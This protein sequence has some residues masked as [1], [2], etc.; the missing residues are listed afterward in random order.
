M[1]AQADQAR[2]KR[3]SKSPPPDWQQDG[4]G[5]PPREQ[6]Q[7][8]RRTAQAARVDPT[9]PAGR[10]HEVGGDIHP[11][12][13]TLHDRTR[14]TDPPRPPKGGRA[15]I[16]RGSR[17]ARTPPD[18]HAQPGRAGLR[19]NSPGG[20]SDSATK[21]REWPPVEA[22]SGG[23]R[24]AALREHPRTPALRP[25]EPGLAGSSGVPR[26]WRSAQSARLKV[27]HPS[28]PLTSPRQLRHD[29]PEIGAV[30]ARLG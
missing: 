11:R 1:A 15:Y 2:V 7:I 20:G 28:R 6:D 9:E 21:E 29:A 12:G 4:H 5:K 3:W 19:W 25:A 10:S 24:S 17:A 13:M 22:T 30:A 23:G 16:L 27:L 8:G 26:C 18:P 14:L